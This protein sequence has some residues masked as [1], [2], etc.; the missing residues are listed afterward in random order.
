[1]IILFIRPHSVLPN[2]NS[3]Q[4]HCRI[5]VT[6]YRWRH[7]ITILHFHFQFRSCNK[8]YTNYTIIILS[9]IS[10]KNQTVHRPA[11]I[12]TKQVH[13][14]QT[15]YIIANNIPL[16]FSCSPVQIWGKRS[17]GSWVMIVKKTD[18]QTKRDYNFIIKSIKILRRQ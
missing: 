18:R 11:L 3:H 2:Q 13:C 14:G 7:V 8:D 17:R 5:L 15:S 10:I 6:R 12:V 4:W 9:I 1:M 16:K